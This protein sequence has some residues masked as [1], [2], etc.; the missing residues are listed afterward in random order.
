MQ[1]HSS[2]VSNQDQMIDQSVKGIENL[3]SNMKDDQAVS[4]TKP[5]GLHT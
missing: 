4:E 5:G 2:N 3:I 1:A